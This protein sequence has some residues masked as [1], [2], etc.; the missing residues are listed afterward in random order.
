MTMRTVVKCVFDVVMRNALAKNA[1]PPS[2]CAL[3]IDGHTSDGVSSVLSV[4]HP[5][6]FSVLLEGSLG[7]TI[8]CCSL[9][10]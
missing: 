1:T 8:Q 5:S 9:S 6:V 3:R 4:I 2:P 7:Y 10:Y